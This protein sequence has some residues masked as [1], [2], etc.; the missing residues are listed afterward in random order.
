MGKKMKKK[1]SPSL[2]GVLGNYKRT[3]T[4][5]LSGFEIRGI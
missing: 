5:N 2:V 1:Y 4:K 3:K